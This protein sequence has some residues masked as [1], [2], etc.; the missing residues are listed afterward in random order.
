MILPWTEKMRNNLSF[1][2]D[3]V[4][5]LEICRVSEGGLIWRLQ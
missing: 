3:L 5:M 2:N 4:A 1:M